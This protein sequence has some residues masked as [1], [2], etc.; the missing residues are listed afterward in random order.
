[1]GADIETLTVKR[2]AVGRLWLCFSVIEQVAIPN[3]VTPGQIA[4]FD[5][6]LKTFLTDHT[7]K[8]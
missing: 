7:G 4:G 2:N 6:G 3:G 8:E 5:F 1:M